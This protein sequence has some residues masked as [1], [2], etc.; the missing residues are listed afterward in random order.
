MMQNNMQGMIQKI[1]VFKGLLKGD[2][3]RELQKLLDSG[4]VPQGMLNQAQEM[5]K[6]IYEAMKEL[7]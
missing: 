7:M 1:K 5:A 2:P 3:Q 4:Q 6:P